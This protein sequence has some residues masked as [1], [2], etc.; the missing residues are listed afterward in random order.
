M[1]NVG[2]IKKTIIKISLHTY[3]YMGKRKSFIINSI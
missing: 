1:Y 2:E 3:M